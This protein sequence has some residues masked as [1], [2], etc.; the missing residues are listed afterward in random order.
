[1]GLGDL[2]C[3]GGKQA[4]TPRLD[5]LASEGMRITSNFQTH[6][7]NRSSKQADFHDPKAPSIARQMKATG[8]ATGHFGKWH[9]GGGRDVEDAPKISAYG[10]DKKD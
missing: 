6:E 7:G 5:R 2:G 9:L 1:M 3:Y 10:F 8:Y 4:P